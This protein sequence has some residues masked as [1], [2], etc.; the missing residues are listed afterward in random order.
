MRISSE[1]FPKIISSIYLQH[2]HALFVG[3]TEQYP[4]V[5]HSFTELRFT[6]T[7]SDSWVI[8]LY[9]EFFS[10]CLSLLQ[11]ALNFFSGVRTE[12]VQ[13]TCLYID[14]KITKNYKRMCDSDYN[15]MNIFL[16]WKLNPKSTYEENHSYWKKFHAKSDERQQV[17]LCTA[18]PKFQKISTL[19]IR[20]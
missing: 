7:A 19:N 2:K 20:D 4:H 16:V 10:C 8:K 12:L 15:E 13:L 6:M 1:S 3:I 17:F 18:I 5:H 11:H 14:M 9:L